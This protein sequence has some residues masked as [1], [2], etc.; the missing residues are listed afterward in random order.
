MVPYIYKE[1]SVLLRVTYGA[2]QEAYMPM[3]NE[4]YAREWATNA[5]KARLIGSAFIVERHDTCEQI[6]LEN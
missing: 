3:P 4:A 6:T 2:S 5:L 1:T